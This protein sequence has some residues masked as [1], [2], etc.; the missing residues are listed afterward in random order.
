MDKPNMFGVLRRVVPKHGIKVGCGTE[1]IQQALFEAEANE[2][3]DALQA[4]NPDEEYA[5]FKVVY[6]RFTKL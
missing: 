1:L 3:A 5:V 4:K 6:V 2:L